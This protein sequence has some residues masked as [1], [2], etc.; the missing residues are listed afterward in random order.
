MP[1]TFDRHPDAWWVDELCEQFRQHGQDYEARQMELRPAVGD[2]A[3]IHNE[4]K[5]M[6]CVEVKMAVALVTPKGELSCTSQLRKVKN[7]RSLRATIR[8]RHFSALNPV[9][10]YLLQLKSS[11]G[12]WLVLPRKVLPDAWFDGTGEV[13]TKEQDLG[14]IARYPVMTWLPEDPDF[15]KRHL[16]LGKPSDGSQFVSQLESILNL[17]DDL[18]DN[19]ERPFYLPPTAQE[20]A[21]FSRQPQSKQSDRTSIFDGDSDIDIRSE[22]ITEVANTRAAASQ[23]GWSQALF[24][25]V[26][27]GRGWGMF[28]PLH[29][30]PSE[31]QAFSP[32]LNSS[33]RTA[34]PDTP[35]VKV[36]FACISLLDSLIAVSAYDRTPFEHAVRKNERSIYVLSPALTT[37]GRSNGEGIEDANIR[38]VVPSEH[39]AS[40]ALRSRCNN[41]RKK[42]TTIGA[43]LPLPL[44]NDDL[45][46]AYAMPIA[47]VVYKLLNMCRQGGDLATEFFGDRQLNCGCTINVDEYFHSHKTIQ[48]DYY[49]L[50]QS[51]AQP[52]KARA[53]VFFFGNYIYLSVPCFAGTYLHATYP[54]SHTGSLLIPHAC[55]KLLVK[56]YLN[57]DHSTMPKRK[58]HAPAPLENETEYLG[59][60]SI[61]HSSREIR[62]KKARGQ[63]EDDEKPN[64]LIRVMRRHAKSQRM[65]LD[66]EEADCS[67]HTENAFGANTIFDLQTIGLDLSP[68]DELSIPE[69]LIEKWKA[70]EKEKQVK[71]KRIQNSVRSGK[72]HL[73]GVDIGSLPRD[74]VDALFLSAT[75]RSESLICTYKACQSKKAKNLLKLF[76]IRE[77]RVC[78]PCWNYW[79]SRGVMRDEKLCLREKLR[80]KAKTSPTFTCVNIHCQKETS[81]KSHSRILDDQRVCEACYSYWRRNDKKWRP[82]S[83]CHPERF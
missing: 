31:C 79:N 3:F 60:T 71:A 39:L 35:F 32:F 78:K 61:S 66:T 72:A 5:D 18:H 69:D 74:E 22:D 57:L 70:N 28:Y 1:P 51:H 24:R 33:Y 56:Y 83:V 53:A 43:P 59:H 68:P 42:G 44:R 40:D 41:A 45:I 55:P 34:H 11:K 30:H 76:L 47:D 8:G 10:I 7:E 4:T 6:I 52:R 80:E 81:T 20:H 15:L 12:G 14:S 38:Y 65:H 73:E 25:S 67:R 16:L 63:Q 26:E 64:V 46:D 37:G 13:R 21:D 49:E 77:H 27:M 29:T 9:D 58:R 36:H 23:D 54:Q 62:A 2:F 48:A 17:Y 50:M 82:E 75:G 19:K